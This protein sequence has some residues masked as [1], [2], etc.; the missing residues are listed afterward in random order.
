MARGHLL[1]KVISDGDLQLEPV[2]F[3]DNT[4]EGEGMEGKLAL[5][6]RASKVFSTPPT[7]EMRVAFFAFDLDLRGSYTQPIKDG[8]LEDMVCDLVLRTTHGDGLGGE[9]NPH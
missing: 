2:A 6:H 3:A 7:T 1:Q 5:L 8:S 9:S 4:T